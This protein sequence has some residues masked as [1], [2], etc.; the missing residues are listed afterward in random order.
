MAVT[1]MGGMEWQGRK[2]I[3]LTVPILFVSCCVFFMFCLD[4]QLKSEVYIHLGWGH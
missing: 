3:C 4:L 1:I 2:G